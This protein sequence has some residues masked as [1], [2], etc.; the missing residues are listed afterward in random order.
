MSEDVKYDKKYFE[1][2]RSELKNIFEQIKPDLQDLADYFAP[3]A[4]RFIA[5]NVNKPHVRFPG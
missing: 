5:R 3:N 4:V 2:R 1:Q